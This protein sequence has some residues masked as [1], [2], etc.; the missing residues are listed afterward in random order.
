MRSEFNDA[1]ESEI[2]FAYI[3][4]TMLLYFSKRTCHNANF[5]FS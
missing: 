2:F 5:V 3:Y 1:F 4:F